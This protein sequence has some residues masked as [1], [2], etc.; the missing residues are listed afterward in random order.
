MNSNLK[1][2]FKNKNVEVLAPAGSFDIMKAVINAGADAVY[3]GG[4]LFGA[5]A[6]ANNFSEEELLRAIDFA[7]LHD[8]RIYL[9]VNTLLK[10]NE[11]CSQLIEYLRPYYEEGLDAVIVQDL[12]VMKAIHD[13]FPDMHIHASTQMTVTGSFGAEILKNAGASR[14]VTAR[15]LNFAEIKDIKSKCDIEIESFVH[16]A[17]CYCYSGQCLFSSMNGGRSGNRGRCAQP[18]RMPYEV[19]DGKSNHLNNTN[20]K[21]VLS[22]KDM[23]TLNILPDIIDAGVYSLKIEGRMKNITYA[24]GVTHMYRKYVDMY[25]ENG[26]NGYNVAE[27]DINYLMDIYNRGLF[28]SGYYNNSKGRKMLSLNR[29]NH[30]GTKA[31]KVVNNNNGLVT[32]EALNDIELHDVFEIDADNSFTSGER[33][34]TGGRF[35]VNLPKKYKLNKGRVLYRTKSERIT[36]EINEKY[37]KNK[38]RRKVNVAV[39]IEEGCDISLTISDCN[40]PS[41]F[42]VSMGETAQSAI[43]QPLSEEK[44]INQINRFNETDFEAE[45]ISINLKGNVFIPVK[46]LNELRRNAVNSF[47]EMIIRKYKRNYEFKRNT[48]VRESEDEKTYALSK[49]MGVHK[50]AYVK[51]INQAYFLF[52]KDSIDEIYFDFTLFSGKSGEVGTILKKCHAAG[53]KAV[54]ALPYILRE[55][56]HDKCSNLIISCAFSTDKNECVDAFLVRNIEEIGLIS[57]LYGENKIMVSNIITDENLYT[58]NSEAISNLKRIISKCKL[59][60]LRYTLPYELTARELTGLNENCQVHDAKKELVV[61]S[62]LP[63]M[64]SEQC[65]YKTFDKCRQNNHDIN[66]VSK[67]NNRYS[68]DNYCEYCYSLISD[69]RVFNITDLEDEIDKINPDYIRYEFIEKDD[70]CDIINNTINSND[71]YHGHFM[72][73]VE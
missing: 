38:I 2:N 45:Q 55:K 17:L 72:L 36:E 11:L 12:G 14:I 3:L 68:V 1:D 58:W 42:V 4:N 67:N 48:G 33:I 64:V 7:H 9:T 44:I 43:K 59:N 56:N 30:M 21:Y 23:C 39:D 40:D 51:N 70:A 26:R 5:R 29:P 31:L 20:E 15:E 35:K 10:E 24:A 57:Q 46:Q 13:N 16:G 6:Y 73:G 69:A 8:R 18:C 52:D 49:N 34:K 61:Y 65:V 22:P 62:R 37:V 60:F 32:F 19:Y 63:L 28:T 27:K 50:C 25:L 71:F 66:I 41:L 47:E 53:K 54:V